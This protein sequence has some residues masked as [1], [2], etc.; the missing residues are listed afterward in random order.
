M[1]R[2]SIALVI[3]LFHTSGV[4]PFRKI[5]AESK[6]KGLFAVRPFPLACLSGS[7]NSR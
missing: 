3:E 1:S 6:D 4:R 7:H 2:P 5:G